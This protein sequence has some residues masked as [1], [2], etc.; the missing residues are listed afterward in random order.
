MKNKKGV[1]IALETWIY[2]LLFMALTGIVYLGLKA[3]LKS[4][5]VLP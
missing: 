1:E 5:G 3:L 4:R 2:I